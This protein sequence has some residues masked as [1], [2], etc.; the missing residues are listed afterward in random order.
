MTLIRCRVLRRLVWVYTICLCP[1]L[2]D[3]SLYGLTKQINSKVRKLTDK[4]KDIPKIH[5]SENP[6]RKIISE[7][8]T[9]TVSLA[10]VAEKELEFV[11]GCSSYI[12]DTTDFIN[13]RDISSLLDDSGDECNYMVY[14]SIPNEEGLAASREA[15]ASRMEQRIADDEMI[16]MMCLVPETEKWK[17]RNWPVQRGNW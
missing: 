4:M 14:H 15:V 3:A 16:S 10:E 13:I 1:N 7:T 9:P 2:W 5:K 17:Y 12:S 11:V 6:R 8:G